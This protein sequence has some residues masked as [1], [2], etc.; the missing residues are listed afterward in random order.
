MSSGCTRWDPLCS[1]LYSQ[2]AE[3]YSEKKTVKKTKPNNTVVVSDGERERTP[4]FE[5]IGL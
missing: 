1:G 2:L 4:G 3:K 5:A